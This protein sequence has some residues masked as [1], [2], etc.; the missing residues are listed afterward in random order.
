MGVYPY[1]MLTAR[2]HSVLEAII[3]NYVVSATP[4]SSKH[5]AENGHY[6]ASSATI[7]AT[8]SDLTDQ[9]YLVQPHTSA[10]RVPTQ[11]GYRFFVNNC[12]E[13]RSLSAKERRHIDMIASWRELLQ[14]VSNQA[15]VCAVAARTDTDIPLVFGISEVLRS[16]EFQHP[17]AAY[18]FGTLVDALAD[19]IHMYR[20]HM[21]YDTPYIFIEEENP[22]PQARSVSIVASLHKTNIVL[23]IGPARMDYEMVTAML[24]S[25]ANMHFTRYNN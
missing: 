21:I 9:G 4:V 2:E 8:M 22:L 3:R 18:E 16:P 20:N 23:A 6:S 25:C 10:G 1:T 5:I 15:H 17:M 19:G 7:R 12:L 11:K 13:D 24:K 14:F